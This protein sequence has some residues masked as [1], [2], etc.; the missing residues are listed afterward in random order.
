[1]EQGKGKAKEIKNIE[2]RQW[3]DRLWQRL[4]MTNIKCTKPSGWRLSF[5]QNYQ[6]VGINNCTSVSHDSLCVLFLPRWPIFLSVGQ[7]EI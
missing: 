4:Y 6:K 1:M 2:R 3:A 5:D 7:T